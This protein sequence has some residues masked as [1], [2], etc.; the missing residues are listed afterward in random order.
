MVRGVVV[1][2]LAGCYQPSFQDGTPCTITH[3]CPASM[4]CS[5]GLCVA[6]PSDGGPDDATACTAIVDGPGAITAPRVAAGIVIDGDLTDWPTCFITLD[7]RNA[8]V[9]DLAN[10]GDYSTGRF[11]V[12]HDATHVYIAAEVTGA[13]PLGDQPVPAIYENDSISIYLDA[14]GVFKTAAYDPDAIQIVVDHANRSQGFRSGQLVTTPGLVTATRTTGSTFAIEIALQPSTL[15]AAAFASTI[16]FD[17][18]FES[19]DG[20]IQTS[21][22]VWF[23]SCRPP[24]CGCTSGPSAPYCDARQFGTA[25]LAP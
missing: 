14:D 6:H 12:A 9:R 19:G 18:G 21:E 10:V 1:V 22:L 25:M 5:H 20:S 15:S 23:E 24:T 7:T 8:V 17:I 11:A 4:T 13:P 2:A 16:G 3:E